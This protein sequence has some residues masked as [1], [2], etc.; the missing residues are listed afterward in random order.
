MLLAVLA[1]GPVRA[2]VVLR[3]AREC[4]IKE[5]TL[6]LAAE[7]VGVERKRHGFG[8]GSF[9]EWSLNRSTIPKLD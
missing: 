5:S 3:Q 6:W 7:R 8:A 4:S 1:E 2:A 9:V